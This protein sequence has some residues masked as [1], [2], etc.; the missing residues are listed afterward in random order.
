MCKT[1]A[2]TKSIY[3][4]VEEAD[5][6]GDFGGESKVLLLDQAVL[7]ADVDDLEDLGPT[8]SRQGYVAMDGY[9]HAVEGLPELCVGAE[10][11]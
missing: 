3:S 5:L 11:E 2:E 8:D 6:A 7:R 4:F 10:R 1:V 9:A